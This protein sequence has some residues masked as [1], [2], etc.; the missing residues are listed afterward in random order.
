MK[1]KHGKKDSAV[2]NKGGRGKAYA[3]CDKRLPFGQGEKTEEMAAK[4]EARERV[5]VLIKKIYIKGGQ[6]NYL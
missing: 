5:P 4:K 6:F 3:R 2:A 1:K